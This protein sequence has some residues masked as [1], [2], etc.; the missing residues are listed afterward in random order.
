[1]FIERIQRNTTTY[2][3]LFSQVI[4][5]NLPAPTV[6]FKEEDLT[7]FDVLMEQR[8]FNVNQNTQRQIATGL[9][10]QGA[11]NPSTAKCLIPPELSRNY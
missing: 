5:E 7:T 9:A 8:R 3:N 2:V 4:D 6:N 1:M 10:N 11:Q